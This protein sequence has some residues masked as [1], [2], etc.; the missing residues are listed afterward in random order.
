VLVVIIVSNYKSTY[1]NIVYSNSSV[2]SII[3]LKN[4]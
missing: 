3:P 1:Y 4:T 2:V